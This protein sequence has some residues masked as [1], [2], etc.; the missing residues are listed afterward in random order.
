MKLKRNLKSQWLKESRKGGEPR[1]WQEPKI[2]LE[3][4]CEINQLLQLAPLYILPNSFTAK[5]MFPNIV[6]R[7]FTNH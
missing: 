4:E 7:L 5:K 6:F 2:H 1:Q 3:T